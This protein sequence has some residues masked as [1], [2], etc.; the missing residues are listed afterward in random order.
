MAWYDSNWDHRKE[1]TL[2]A[3]IVTA[4]QTDIPVLVRLTT[5]ADLAASALANG[6]DILFTAADETTQ[7]P[8]SI[9]NFDNSTGELIV[10]VFIS[11]LSAVSDT[12]IYMYYGNSGASNQENGAGVWADYE[13]VW[14][15]QE[16]GDGTSG[17][18]VDA[19]GNSADGTGASGAVPTRVS[20]WNGLYSQD[21]DGTDDA[22]DTGT[23]DFA[24]QT[25]A[26]LII[27]AEHDNTGSNERLFGQDWGS[28]SW[29]QTIDIRQKNT[30]P[31]SGG[32]V[33]TD[34]TQ[35]GQDDELH[36]AN[37]AILWAVVWDAADTVFHNYSY[38][39]G[40]SGEW[41]DNTA[42][43]SGT[44]INTDAGRD[45]FLG[46][47]NT[48]RQ[49]G[50]LPFDGK[51]W[52]ARASF[53]AFSGD[54][55]HTTAQIEEDPSGWVTVGSEEDAPASG[56]TY[57]EGA[58]NSESIVGVANLTIAHDTGSDANDNLTGS[59]SLTIAHDVSSTVSEQ[60]DGSAFL[61]I[62][63]SQGATFSEGI[64]GNA[65]LAIEHDTGSAIDE[66]ITGTSSLEIVHD[67]GTTISEGIVGQADLTFQSSSGATIQDVIEGQASL[68]IAHDTPGSIDENITGQSNLNI[69]HDVSAVFMEG[70]DGQADLNVASPT[71][72]QGS[73][74]ETITGTAQLCIAHD[75][76]ANVSESIAGTTSFDI[77][78]NVLATISDGIDGQA[79]LTVALDSGGLFSEG[80]YGSADLTIATPGISGDVSEGLIGSAALSID[81][82]ISASIEDGLIGDADLTIT[83]LANYSHYIGELTV[84]EIYTGN[85]IVL[86]IYTGQLALNDEVLNMTRVAELGETIP[87][88]LPL[89]AGA[90]HDGAFS[91]P[92]AVT[93][94]ARFN[95]VD[96]V[97]YALGDDTNAVVKDDDEAGAYLANIIALA[98]GTAT[99]IATATWD[100][101]GFVHKSKLTVEVSNP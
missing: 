20:Q 39:T 92:D 7:I 14:Y 80:I 97:T 32:V 19:S 77:E 65:L 90:D 8:H 34:S 94:V 83:E 100:A 79:E 6:D 71:D 28:F 56:T 46:I 68:T 21:F 48:T 63:L 45:T 49:N 99:F 47:G 72:I 15:L 51:L 66:G 96:A 24:G 25:A 88:K 70:L 59:G 4:T 22:I 12:T 54:Y 78:H 37:N 86:E 75:T 57:D 67:A 30:D 27:W 43:I 40:N 52:L 76:G 17:E 69:A 26:S 38:D 85:L 84:L 10:Y 5:D 62:G 3:S 23:V 93:I 33:F 87:L 44:E 18:F 53:N 81:H 91:E 42:T 82:D 60:V 101:S 58:D 64:D 61:T 98:A 36:T 50:S 31:R 11:S 16:S 35:G 41:S 55:L 2:D 95:G 13:G 74:E 9:V 1:I 29:M 89:A 73:V